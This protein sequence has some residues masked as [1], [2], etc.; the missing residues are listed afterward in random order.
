MHVV[1]TGVFKNYDGNLYENSGPV[2]YR[3]T[4]SALLL[5]ISVIV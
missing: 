2:M 1:V 5:N 4:M 3:S